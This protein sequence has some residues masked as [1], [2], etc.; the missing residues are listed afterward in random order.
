MWRDVRL[1][2]ESLI[3]LRRV[4]RQLER[5]GD[6]RELVA[7]LDGTASAGAVDD[8]ASGAQL[9]RATDR[10]VRLLGPSKDACVP[11]S[12]TLMVLWSG[13]A[14]PADFV[15]GVNRGGGELLGHAWLEAP[16]LDARLGGR[17]ESPEPYAEIFRYANRWSS[18]RP[19]GN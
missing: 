11:R 6:L 4:R 5:I 13:R 10:S 1:L 14:R 18:A 2:I 15:S 16:D 19:A 9:V 12:L 7:D 17:V 3:A 8:G